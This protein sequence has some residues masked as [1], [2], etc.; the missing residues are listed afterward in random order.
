MGVEMKWLSEHPHYVAASLIALAAISRWL[1]HPSNVAPIT[2]VALFSGVYLNKKIAFLVP[3]IS[4]L[5]SDMVIGFYGSM[6]LFVYGSF[7]ISSLIGMSM[8]K[9]K[10]VHTIILASLMSSILFFLITNFGV[11]LAGTMYTKDIQGLFTSYSAGLPFFRNTLLGDM[12]YTSVLF[13]SYVLVTSPKNIKKMFV[14]GF[15]VSSI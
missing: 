3:L 14:G 4:M 2:A 10:S 9:S 11:W 12:F 1:P 5:I 6:M 15:S 8:K 7:F 13:G